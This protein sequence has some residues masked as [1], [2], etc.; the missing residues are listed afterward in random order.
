M[1]LLS[2]DISSST[3]WAS[4][5]TDIGPSSLKYGVIVL[6]RRLRDYARHPWGYYL[7]AKAMAELLIQQVRIRPIDEV[8]V[9]ET[10]GARSRF[11]QKGLEYLHFAF[12]DAFAKEHTDIKLTYLN[13]SEWRK[14]TAT[15][16][17]REDK[18]R[19]AK[20]SRHKR[21]AKACGQKLDK[22][23]LGIAGKIT[24]KH[25]AIRRV[26]ELYGIELLAKDDDIADAVLL[27]HAYL[28][29]AEPCTGNDKD[30]ST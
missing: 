15:K 1:R 3:G 29:G 2:F 16:M 21:R 23:T 14:V 7:G 27:L 20:L 24:I 8:V 28:N 6:P 10:N 9:E 19:N 17:S 5:D 30:E 11:T 4:I 26:R 12:L 25:V 18:N 13:T 22:K